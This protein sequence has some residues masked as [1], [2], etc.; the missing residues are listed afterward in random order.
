MSVSVAKPLSEI[1]EMPIPVVFA[2]K[3]EL[4]KSSLSLV[5]DRSV[6]EVMVM[7]PEPVSKSAETPLKSLMKFSRSSTVLSSSTS[8]EPSS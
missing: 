8:K 2:V 1:A 4:A 3:P 6:S 5:S 7:R